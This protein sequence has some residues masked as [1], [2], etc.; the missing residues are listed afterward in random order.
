MLP[1]RRV[2]KADR[3]NALLTA[4]GQVYRFRG[5]DDGVP[6]GGIDLFDDIGPTFQPGPDAGAVLPRH[7]LPDDRAAGTGGSAQE[8]KLEGAS[9]QGLVGHTIIFLDDNCV[10]GLVL[11][12]CVDKKDTAQNQQNKI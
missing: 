10:Q 7:L 12:P 6:V 2:V 9:G 1:I 4:V 11:E 3:D 8:A 5:I